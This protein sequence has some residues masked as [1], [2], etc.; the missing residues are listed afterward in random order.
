MHHILREVLLEVLL[1]LFQ[2]LLGALFANV[3]PA[4]LDAGDRTIIDG[5]NVEF[6]QLDPFG[7]IDHLPID[8]LGF[9]VL[10]DFL[11]KAHHLFHEFTSQ[12]LQR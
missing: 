9:D 6:N 10:Q 4:A 12:F 11:S 2:G 5:L 1:G 3:C 8:L 7:A